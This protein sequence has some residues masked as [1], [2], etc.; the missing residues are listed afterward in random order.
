MNF[1]FAE[2]DTLQNVKFIVR[3]YRIV[4]VRPSCND[5]QCSWR[6]SN[7]IQNNRFKAN[8]SAAFISLY[9]VNAHV[10]QLQLIN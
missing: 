4:D 8:R 10:S 9:S 7:V 5:M 1:T 3:C 6:K 2:N